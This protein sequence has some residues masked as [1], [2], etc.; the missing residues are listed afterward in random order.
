MKT[1]WQTLLNPKRF[2]KHT[3][4]RKLYDERNEFENDYTR[5]ILS[6]H[7]RRLQDKTQVF[8][9]DDTDFVRTRLTHSLE[10]SSFARSLGLSVEKKLIEDK[11]LS[12]E[13]SGH[14][15][16]ILATAGLIHDI[17][18]PPFGHFGE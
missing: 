5:I 9:Y 11:K 3:T 14:I 10:V 15:P 8:P 1:K 4:G 12:Q 18:N 13:L 16:S 7:F 2:R 6:P 17:G